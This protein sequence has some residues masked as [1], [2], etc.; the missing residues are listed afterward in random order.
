[1][2]DGFLQAQGEAIYETTSTW[3]G[4]LSAETQLRPL[5]EAKEGDLTADVDRI[6]EKD[7]ERTFM[8]PCQ[9][10]ALSR[11]M[12]S[13]AVE[14]K[15]YAQAMSYVGGFLMLMHDEETSVAMMRVLN[16]NPKYIPGYWT[17][18][19]IAFAT[20]A[21]V[22]LP[23]L[24][25]HEPEVAKLLKEK[26]CI[27]P[28][29]YLQKW[30]VALCIQSLPFELGVVYLKHFFEGGYIFLFQFAIALHWHF[31]EK[32]LAA[33]DHAEVYSILRLE[34]KVLQETPITEA[35]FAQA[36]T[37]SFPD[38]DIDKA[39]QTAYDTHLKA[40]IERARQLAE[41]DDDLSDF[42]DEDED[43]E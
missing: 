4:L 23:L 30:W 6:I 41:E 13:L 5:Q 24:E 37:Y 33:K 12:R 39:R 17:T 36:L 35:V 8:Q 9:R 43:D 21:Y 3:A 32:L 16:G 7:A 19:A 29:T 38:L 11:V 14:F 25:A 1:M 2:D 15:N 27:M 10:E 40:R 31:K 20:D 34:R 18:E 26:F 28:E 22:F 42:D